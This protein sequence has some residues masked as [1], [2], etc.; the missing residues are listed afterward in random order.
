MSA[1]AL[2]QATM[3]SR[4]IAKLC[5]KQHKNVIR[6]IRVMLIEIFGAEQA[7]RIVPEHQRNRHTEYIREN[8]GA[9]MDA[10]FGD[11]PD[12]SHHDKRGFQWHRDTRGYVSEF[13]LSRELTETLITG[14]SI[15]LR[16]KV[17]KRLHELERAIQQAVPLPAPPAANDSAVEFLKL[18]LAHLPNLPETSKQALLS[19]GSELAFGQRLIPLPKVEEH[20]MTAG[21]VGKLLGVSANKIG[22]LANANELKVAPYGEFRL[23]KSAYSSKQVES[24]YYSAAGV[25]RLRELIPA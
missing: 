10:I 19:Y 8:A 12:R 11:G 16:H 2:Q 1:V 3:S 20:L 18:A 4:E 24:F 15:P 6:D 13:K 17:I 21:E 22:R 25:E 23:D 7:E 5:Q 9:I 14:Y